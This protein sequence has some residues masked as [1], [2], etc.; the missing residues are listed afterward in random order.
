MLVLCAKKKNI[1]R[2]IFE[3]ISNIISISI[4]LLVILVYVKYT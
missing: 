2:I 3:N 4:I 1:Q